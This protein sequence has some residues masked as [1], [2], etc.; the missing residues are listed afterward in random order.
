MCKNIS[1]VHLVGQHFAFFASYSLFKHLDFCVSHS[2]FKPV[3]LI[4]F[5]PLSD[6]QKLMNQQKI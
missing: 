3:G 5:A 6:L 4:E 1:P 2:F